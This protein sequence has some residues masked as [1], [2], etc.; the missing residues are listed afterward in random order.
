MDGADDA[1]FSSSF[2]R[3]PFR[4]EAELEVATAMRMPELEGY[5][6]ELREGVYRGN[7]KAGE[8]PGYH[9]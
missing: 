9:R 2:V 4:W 1:P 6:V 7:L 8:S 5:V 3:V